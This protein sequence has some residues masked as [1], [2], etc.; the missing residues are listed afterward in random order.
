[1][2]WKLWY[3]L[4]NPPYNTPLFQRIYR[5]N[6]P[7]GRL[8]RILQIS[9]AY[10][11][12]CLVFTLIWPALTTN[13]AFVALMIIAASNNLFGIIWANRIA[14]TLARE[15]EL[16]TFDLLCLIPMGRF[17][18]VWSLST[19]SLHATHMFRS[20]GFLVRWLSIGFIT[21]LGI[22]LLIPLLLL[23]Q[24]QDMEVLILLHPLLYAVTLALAFYVDYIQAV[25]TASV[26]GMLASTY[27]MNTVNVRI[28]AVG[29]FLLL[30][31]SVYLVTLIM[32]F[33][34]AE[35]IFSP[36]IRDLPLITLLLPIVRLT[37]FYLLHEAVIVLSWRLLLQRFNGH[38][39]SLQHLST[40]DL[41]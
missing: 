30:Q 39:Q 11:F 22:A 16:Q 34:L 41:Q 32:G 24:A 15:N 35:S 14:V 3:A 38:I 37:I 17:G 29:N 7:Q 28:L 31:V 27:T 4:R 40:E 8:R 23:T 36:Y 25:V 1:M 5:S 13:F 2:T 33:I 20:M 21:T 10:L 6:N 26:I 19:A 9:L 18:A 12:T